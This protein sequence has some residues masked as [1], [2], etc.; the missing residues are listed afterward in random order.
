[1]NTFGKIMY[2]YD[3]IVVTKTGHCWQISM[4]TS[5]YCIFFIILQFI[6]PDVNVT[7]IKI[8]YFKSDLC[9]MQMLCYVCLV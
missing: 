4:G 6:Y 1:M 7:D 9:R 8:V 5:Q 3:M 2:I